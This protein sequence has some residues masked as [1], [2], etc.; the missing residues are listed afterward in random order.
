MNVD[1]DQSLWEAWAGK[2]HRW[3][4]DNWVAS[5][6]ELLGPLAFL[7]AQFVYIVKP[8]IGRSI[9]EDHLDAA[10]RLMEDTRHI[11][12][13]TRMLRETPSP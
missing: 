7:G 11:E 10:A 4:F 9:P 5:F 6:L 1:G 12:A 3:G 13:F 2:I 8:F